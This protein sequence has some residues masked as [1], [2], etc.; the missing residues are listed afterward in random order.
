MQQ[1]PKPC[2]TPEQL[3]ALPDAITPC[4]PTTDVSFG[5]AWPK[6]MPDHRQQGRCYLRRGDALWCVTPRHRSR[7]LAIGQHLTS[8]RHRSHNA[9]DQ[10][11][12]ILCLAWSGRIRARSEAALLTHKPPADF[13]ADQKGLT[14]DKVQ[15][16]TPYPGG[17]PAN[18]A[19][20]L[21]KLGKKV[22]FVSALGYD[23]RGEEL[24]QLLRSCGVDTSAVQRRSEPTRCAGTAD[25]ELRALLPAAAQDHLHCTGPASASIRCIRCLL[26]TSSALV[27]HQRPGSAS[28]QYRWSASTHLQQQALM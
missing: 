3:A 16:W 13:I 12:S 22:L 28:Q 24:M 7:V 23:P 20:S 26:A 8:S 4:Y 14:R 15:S 18:V 27:W 10:P 25:K 5:S 6:S 9:C 21:A 19:T 1:A 17:A 2:P 11:N